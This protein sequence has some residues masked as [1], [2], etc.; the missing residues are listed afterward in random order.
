MAQARRPPL[1]PGD[2]GR[3]EVE[4]VSPPPASSS[5]AEISD[6]LPF[7]VDSA[8]P[9]PLALILMDAAVPPTT[10]LQVEPGGPK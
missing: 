8:P 6:R 3:C 9:G 7:R 5:R 1:P 10:N 4:D 2:Y